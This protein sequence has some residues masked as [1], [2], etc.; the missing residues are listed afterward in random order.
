V[1]VN[2]STFGIEHGL[3][4]KGGAWLTYG[5]V[6]MQGM[7]KGIDVLR[8]DPVLASLLEDSIREKL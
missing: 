8:A 2:Y 6:R 3:I 1:N 5:D 4:K 7:K